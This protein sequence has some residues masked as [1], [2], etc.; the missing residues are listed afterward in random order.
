MG[1]IF[2]NLDNG[3]DKRTLRRKARYLANRQIC[4]EDKIELIE[5]SKNNNIEL[6]QA[7]R[8]ENDFGL[9]FIKVNV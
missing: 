2:N 3:M 1:L 8:K 9:G 4:K 6:V 7:F 5:I